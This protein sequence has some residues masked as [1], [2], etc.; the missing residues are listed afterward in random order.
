MQIKK[1][2]LSPHLL[3]DSPPS[4]SQI[5]PISLTD[6][7][8]LPHRFTPISLT[9]SPHL[10]HRF[11]PSLSRLD[12]P[13]IVDCRTVCRSCLDSLSIASS[14]SLSHLESPLPL[15]PGE[16]TQRPLFDSGTTNPS[17]GIS[18]M[19]FSVTMVCISANSG[20]PIS[21]CGEIIASC[22]L[23]RTLISGVI[24]MSVALQDDWIS[25]I[26]ANGRI[27]ENPKVPGI[28]ERYCRTP[29]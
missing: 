27:Q 1:S 22:T 21:V 24:T 8:Y 2:S 23:G 19:L 13:S 6:S 25:N 17:L 16:S 11:T 18:T 10:P 12:S 5:H 28:Y 9:N 20:I 7:P 26:A 29:S 14:A 3:T 4:H 15:L